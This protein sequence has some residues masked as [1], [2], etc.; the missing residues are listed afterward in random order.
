MKLGEPEALRMFDDHDRRVGNIDTDLDNGRRDEQPCVARLE[1]KH[2]RVFFIAAHP[3]V[4]EP[5]RR[6]H[7]FLEDAAAFFRRC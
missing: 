7:G 2:G 3:S 6:I 1:G 5:H 4:N